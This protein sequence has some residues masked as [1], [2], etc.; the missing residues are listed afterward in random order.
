LVDPPRQ[1]AGQP[2]AKELEDVW[3]MFIEESWRRSLQMPLIKELR[4]LSIFEKMTVLVLEKKGLEKIFQYLRPCVNLIAI[5]LK[6]NRV[7]TRDL[8]QI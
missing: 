8:V 3:D 5:Y 7:I 6:H 1:K 4:N 2:P